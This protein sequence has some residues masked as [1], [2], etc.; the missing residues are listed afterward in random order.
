MA[1]LDSFHTTAIAQ[2]FI[3]V[4]SIPQSHSRIIW[5]Q[6]SLGLNS[7]NYVV[8]SPRW[9]CPFCRNRSFQLVLTWV[10]SCHSHSFTLQPDHASYATTWRFTIAIASRRVTHL[11]H[12]WDL[13][14]V[15]LAT[16]GATLVF[17]NRRLPWMFSVFGVV[18][19]RLN[20]GICASSW[21]FPTRSALQCERSTPFSF[22]EHCQLPTT[23]TGFMTS[24]WSF[25]D[26]LQRTL[27]W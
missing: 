27:P 23:V 17:P 20:A 22:V 14:R 26:F 11:S 3:Y 16:C 4:N 18:L 5:R 1:L 13:T 24:F 21:F 15:D 12:P 25:V 6:T 2:T 7:V 19:F 10:T 9:T 8:Q